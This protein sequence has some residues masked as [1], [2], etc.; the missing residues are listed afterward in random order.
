MVGTSEELKEEMADLALTMA[1]DSKFAASELAEAYFF[2]ASAGF[3]AELS[4]AALAPLLDFATAGA[5]DLATATDLLT[6]AQ[7][8]LGLT[9]ADTIQNM[10]NMV[11]LSD[12]LVKANTLANATVQ[13]FS[14][15]LTNEAGAAIKAFNI[16]V[17]TGVAVLAVYAD[18]GIKGMKA[19]SLFG[20]SL[21]L[22]TKEAVDNEKA[23]KK[24]GVTVFDEEGEVRNFA[25]I[26][27]DMENAFE[28]MSTK[29]RNAALEQ[30]G[31]K[32]RVQ[33]AILPLIG[34]SEKIREYDAG[35]RNAGDITKEVA[36]KQ[37][38]SLANQIKVLDNSFNVFLVTLGETFKPIATDVIAFLKG[39][40]QE[41]TALLKIVDALG[42][43]KVVATAFAREVIDTSLAL[44]NVLLPGSGALGGAAA[45]AVLG[46]SAENQQAI[47]GG[48]TQTLLN[49]MLATSKEQ[50]AETKK[51]TDKTADNTGV[52]GT[53][54]TSVVPLGA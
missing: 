52:V 15:S 53:T 16:D 9:S 11:R 38:L 40:T 32:A 2:L 27:G 49:S 26:I 18:Q 36:D 46:T 19:G 7:S 34:A 10:E 22:L 28:G 25:D 37:M 54:V 51:L 24:L 39:I 35:M 12:V 3:D 14:E 47:A 50:L 20:R 48:F 17:E 21:R 23:F 5:F 1:Q 8:A 45:D 4:M 29:A 33:Q 6:D 44:T 13:Q 41:A 31:F 42:G 30:L 43:V